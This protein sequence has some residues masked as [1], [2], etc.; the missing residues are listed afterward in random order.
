MPNIPDSSVTSKVRNPAEE[1]RPVGPTTLKAELTFGKPNGNTEWISSAPWI[2]SYLNYRTIQVTEGAFIV[3]AIYDQDRRDWMAVRHDRG[4]H[5]IGGGNSM[6][7]IMLPVTEAYVPL[8]VRLISYG[9]D[10]GSVICT[11]RYE[12]R[13]RIEASQLDV[14]PQQ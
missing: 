6:D 9:D 5:Y 11:G 7:Y 10:R 14:R 3:V 1:N 2:E 4:E 8:Q 12:W 13:H